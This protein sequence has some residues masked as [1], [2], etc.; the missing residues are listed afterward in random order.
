MA[1]LMD[2]EAPNFHTFN[3]SF[4]GVSNPTPKTPKIK[5]KLLRVARL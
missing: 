4:V 1:F 3:G 5:I 2:V